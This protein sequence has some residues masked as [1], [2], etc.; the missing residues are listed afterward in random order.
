[1]ICFTLWEERSC[2]KW[3]RLETGKSI[4][5][6]AKEEASERPEEKM[7]V[8][9]Y[10]VY[11]WTEQKTVFIKILKKTLEPIYNSNQKE[12]IFKKLSKQCTKPIWKNF[13]SLKKQKT[14]TNRNEYN[15][16]G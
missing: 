7:V 13:K 8:W 2:A 14:D 9:A 15:V 12:K 3:G 4:S 10:G 11:T 6:E 1:M 16:L 5:R